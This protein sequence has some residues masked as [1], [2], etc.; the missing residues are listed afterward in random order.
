M[1]PQNNDRNGEIYEQHKTQTPLRST[2][3]VPAVGLRDGNHGLCRR[4]GRCSQR[5]GEHLEN[6]LWSDQNRG[7]QCGLPRHR[8]DL[9]SILLRQTGDGLFRLQKKRP[10]RVD[11]TCHPFCLPGIHADGSAVYLADHRDLRCRR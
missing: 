2:G 6:S 11:S 3:A 10:V 4:H 5:R 8:P 7:E 1:L 9:G